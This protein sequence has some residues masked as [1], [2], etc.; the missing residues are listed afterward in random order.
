M[1]DSGKVDPDFLVNYKEKMDIYNVPGVDKNK[2]DRLMTAGNPSY[3]DKLIAYTK[4][5]LG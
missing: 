5:L 1:I 3:H 2:V 4:K